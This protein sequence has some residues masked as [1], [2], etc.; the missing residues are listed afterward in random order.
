M[1]RSRKG[2]AVYLL[3]AFAGAWGLWAITTLTTEVSPQSPLFQLLMLPGAF[4][5]ALAAFVVRKWVTREGF[6]DTGLKPNLRRWQPYLFALIWPLFAVA[7]IAVLAVVLGISRPDFTLQ[8]SLAVLAPGAEA[9]ALPPALWLVMPFQ[10][11]ISAVLFTP[12]LWGEEFGW[13][14]YLQVRMFAGRPLLAAVGTGLIW[15]AWHYPLILAGYQFPDDR[16]LGLLVFPVSCVLLSIVFGWLQHRAGSVWAPSLAH[17]ATNVVG[18]S[19]LFLLFAG[20][21]NWILVHY[22]GVIGWIPLVIVCAWIILTGRLE[23]YDEG[24]KSLA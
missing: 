6:A 17:S 9:P 14:G 4:A 24:Q 5:P 7:V 16:V 11:L 12:V 19:M 22:L 18:G 2:I 10:A 3:I 21:P 23:A 8:R 20:G 15:G 1:S 13:R